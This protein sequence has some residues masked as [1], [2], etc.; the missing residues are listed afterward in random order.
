MTMRVKSRLAFPLLQVI[1]SAALMTSNL[2]RP[3]SWSSPAWKAPDRQICGALNAPATLIAKYPV[4][5]ADRLWSRYYPLN[6]VVELIVY[7]SLVW[8]VWYVVSVEMGGKGVSVLTPKTGM[9]KVSD[10]LVIIFGAL[11]GAAGLWVAGQF[12][13]LYGRL[14]STPYLVWALAVLSF[15]GHDLWACFRSTRR[16]PAGKEHSS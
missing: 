16:E 11:L 4:E 6:L 8:L 1:V 12:P 10:A 2:L 7:L 9:R 15:Y 13:G 3:D 5:I 14:V